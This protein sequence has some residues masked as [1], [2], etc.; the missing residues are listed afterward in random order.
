MDQIGVV[1]SGYT[2]ATA[3][4][5][6]S[7]AFDLHHSSKQC[8]ILNPLSKAR[9]QTWVLTDAS[10]VRFLWAMMGILHSVNFLMFEFESKPGSSIWVDLVIFLK[11]SPTVSFYVFLRFICWTNSVICTIVFPLLHTLK[12]TDCVFVSC[13]VFFLFSYFI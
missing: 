7:L 2:T 1:A 9:G 6:Q 12:F 4:P 10:Q 3:T 11:D 8:R 5:H 13:S